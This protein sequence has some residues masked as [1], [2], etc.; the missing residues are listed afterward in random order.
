M[1]RS[2]PLIAVGVA[3]AGALGVAVR[4]RAWNPDKALVYCPVG[5]DAIGCSRVVVA[6]SGW[7][8]RSPGGVDRG[9]EGTAGTIDLATADL[10]P[11][12][13]FII[14]SLADG[15]DSKPYELLRK[16]PVA[17]RLSTM[18]R[19]RLVVWSGTPDQG[20]SNRDLKDKLIRNLA[21]WARADSSV[22]G[23]GIVVLQDHSDDAATRYG[24]LETFAGIAITA[25]TA[26]GI[27]DT[28]QALTATGT[29]ILDNGGEQ[30]AYANMASFGVQPPPEVSGASVDAR[31]GA[32]G[33]Q[34]VLV[35]SPKR[36][37]SL[38]TDKADYSPGD[39]VTF[40]GSGWKPGEGVSLLLHEDTTIHADRTLTATADE[41]GNIFNNEF[42]PEPHDVGVTFYVLASGQASRLV[43]Q[44]RFTDKV[45]PTIT[46]E[47]HDAN[48]TVVTAGPIGTTVHDKATV[49]GTAGAPPG[50]G[51]VQ[52]VTHR[53]RTGAA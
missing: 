16:S 1:R 15:P 18:L 28:V 34:M 42:S 21:V 17:Y 50:T 33:D 44:A 37:A 31:G 10:S 2:L 3:A 53:T 4:A 45:G 8:G 46:T 30:L 32:S 52:R 13:A 23:A 40:T 7:D 29:R 38:K 5:I 39:P 35:T 14:P 19:G 27:Y 48:H 47:I 12:A 26:S 36:L 11:Y 9:Y 51:T 6:W 24:W 41:S 20:T 25:D 22:Q 49:S 43:A